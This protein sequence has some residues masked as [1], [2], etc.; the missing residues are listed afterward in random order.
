VPSAELLYDWSEGHSGQIICSLLVT[1]DNGNVQRL[2][3]VAEK[4]GKSWELNVYT[5]DLERQIRTMYIFPKHHKGRI[6][7]P[8]K[9]RSL[10]AAN[11]Y[12]A[13]HYL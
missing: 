8:V 1:H 7:G 5:S 9:V 13:E 2:N 4:A 3:V 12:V 10:E 6:A 11:E